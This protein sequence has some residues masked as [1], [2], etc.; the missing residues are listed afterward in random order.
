[1][2]P[3]KSSLQTALLALSLYVPLY[4]PLKR[5]NNKDLG[6]RQANEAMEERTLALGQGLCSSGN[7]T[8]IHI[9]IPD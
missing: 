6:A 5:N 8:W 4:R 3:H 2:S 9:L 1:M 7:A